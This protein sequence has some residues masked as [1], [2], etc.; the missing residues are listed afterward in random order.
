MD[1]SNTRSL[2]FFSLT[3]KILYGTF[4]SVLAIVLSACDTGDT[5]NLAET[6]SEQ[7]AAEKKESLKE[8]RIC[9]AHNY[10]AEEDIS[11]SSQ[12]VAKRIRS[13]CEDE[14]VY[15][16]AVK[17]NYAQVPDILSPTQKMV[18]EEVDLVTDFVE[19]SRAKMNQI[20]QEYHEP[21]PML[22][23]GHPPIEGME[24]LEYDQESKGI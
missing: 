13:N 2:K 17:L 7:L 24:M 3:R 1:S 5:A 4:I 6:N 20:Y 16:R 8:L 21:M 10:L 9:F 22:P 14:F 19:Q 23:P 12:Y 15:L 18:E 11:M